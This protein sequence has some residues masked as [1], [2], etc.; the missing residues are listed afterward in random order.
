MEVVGCCDLIEERATEAA[1]LYGAPGAKTYSEYRRLLEDKS[2]DAVYVLTP[3]VAHSPLTVDSLEAG[4]HV[5]CE[6]P[7]G[8]IG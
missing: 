6:K 8:N 4:K 3:N 2:I 5:L 7:S 1:S